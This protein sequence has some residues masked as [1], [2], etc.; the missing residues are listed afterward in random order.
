MPAISLFAVL[1][2]AWIA[3]F[4]YDQNVQDKY[5]AFHNRC[6]AQHGVVLASMKR[7]GDGWVGC[8]TGVKELY[9]E[10]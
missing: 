4:V 6:D 8:Y 1:L 9:N 10:G 5:A 3:V 7:D 2:A